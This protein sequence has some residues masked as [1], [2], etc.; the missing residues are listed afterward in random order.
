MRSHAGVASQMFEVLAKKSINI[1]MISTSE[2]KVSVVIAEEYI[3][4][5]TRALHSAFDLQEQDLKS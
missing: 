3:E 5:A 4:L 1:Q 2:I